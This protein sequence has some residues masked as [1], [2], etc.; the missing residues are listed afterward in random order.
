M[1]N[2]WLLAD[3]GHDHRRAG[4]VAGAGGRGAGRPRQKGP[5]LGGTGAPRCWPPGAGGPRVLLAGRGVR[6]GEADQRLIEPARWPPARW[7]LRRR[8]AG[9]AHSVSILLLSRSRGG[10]LNNPGPGAAAGKPSND[11]SA[12]RRLDRRPVIAL[13]DG[14]RGTGRLAADRALD[15]APRTWKMLRDR[16]RADGSHPQG[17][18]PGPR[19]AHIIGVPHVTQLHDLHASSEASDL[20]VLTAHVVIDESCFHDG[21]PAPVLDQLRGAGVG[22]GRGWQPELGPAR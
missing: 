7:C 8:R 15:P 22:C 3:D 17:R 18:R 21:Q 4:F 6:A 16:R 14:P 5:D 2:R 13:T 10:N 20:P 9:A 11:R 12:G 1:R 19:R